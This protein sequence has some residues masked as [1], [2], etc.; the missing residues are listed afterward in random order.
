MKEDAFR[1]RFM[2]CVGSIYNHLYMSGFVHL[3]SSWFGYLFILCAHLFILCAHLFILCAHLHAFSL[4]VLMCTFVCFMCTF[5][6]ENIRK[7]NRR[8]TVCVR[9][10]LLN[11]PFGAGPDHHGWLPYS[12]VFVTCIWI[13]ICSM[14]KLKWQRNQ[15]WSS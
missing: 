8:Q 6:R 2:L 7:S 3:W 4:I 5:A 12:T 10:F 14:A 15:P 13:F 9:W 11:L 1:I